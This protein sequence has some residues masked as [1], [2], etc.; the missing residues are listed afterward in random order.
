MDVN[1]SKLQTSKL[2][3]LILIFYWYLWAFG[4]KR[5]KKKSV[6]YS[7]PIRI[8]VKLHECLQENEISSM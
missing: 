5:I 4:T 7:C 2:I 3:E 6:F 8:H 1:S